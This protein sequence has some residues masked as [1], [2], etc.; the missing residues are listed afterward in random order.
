MW[1]MWLPW[2][3]RPP[4]FAGLARRSG[5]GPVRSVSQRETIPAALWQRADSLRPA[6]LAMLFHGRVSRTRSAS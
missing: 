1:P 3:V 2:R 6:R 4:R 5:F